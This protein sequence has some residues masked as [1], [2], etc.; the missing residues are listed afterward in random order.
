MSDIDE[1]EVGPPSPAIETDDVMKE[2]ENIE[3]QNSKPLEIDVEEN[4][5]DV[6][7]R[8]I[9]V[10]DK[11]IG[12]EEKEIDVDDK[13]EE[14]K[15]SS[16]GRMFDRLDLIEEI[17]DE[18]TR[19]QDEIVAT[20]K[21][22]TELEKALTAVVARK[23]AVIQRI[24][25]EIT[26]LKSFVQKRKQTYKRKRKEDGAPTRALSAYNLFIKERFQQLAKENEKALKSEDAGAEL[27]RVPPS[28]L[29][30]KTGNEWKELPPEVKAQYEER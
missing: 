5:I 2:K 23:D 16:P 27:K 15:P 12:V 4:E 25:G 29:V 26:K 22:T 20:V 28:N 18:E 14:D 3:N 9:G 21:P 1:N 19:R 24:T 8:E 13:E 17:Q 30:A 7:D 6:D 10:D 11:E